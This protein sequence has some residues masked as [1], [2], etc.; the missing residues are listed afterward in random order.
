M[1]KY[2]S[3]IKA[4]LTS[5][6]SLFIINNK[7]KD[8]NKKQSKAVPI[9]I[10]C[11]IMLCF[12]AYA[13]MFIDPLKQS[14]LA[15]I[16]LSLFAFLT[17][18]LTLIEGIYKTGS[19]LFNCKDDDLLLSLPIKKSTVLFIRIF[20]FYIFELLYN[21]VFM[22]PAVVAY[23]IRVDVE[24]TFY[25]TSFFMLLLLPIIPIAISCIIGVIT[26]GLASRFKY[27]NLVQ[28]I[29][30]TI[31]FVG[32]MYVSFNLQN[33][34]DALTKNATSIN[35]LITKI[36]YPAGAFVNL[37]TDFKIVD[38]LIFIGINAGIFA[39]IVFLISKVYFKINSRTK[40]ISVVYK[41]EYK[42]KTN[43]VMSALIKKEWRRFT[44]SPVFI[45][46][47]G[48]GL[49]LYLIL[50]ILVAVNFNMFSGILS[51]QGFK[52][53]KE[54][55]VKYIPIVSV[56]LIA[57][58]S[59]LTS[60]TSSMISLEGKSFNILKSLPVSASKI[61]LAKV[62][63]AVLVML[64][65]IF[66]GDMILFIKY[67]FTILQMLLVLLVSVI[68]PLIS[69][70]I[71]IIMNLKYPKMDA[72]SDAEVVKQ[73]TSSTISVFVG[74]G[75]LGVTL[76]GLFKLLKMYG[77]DMTLLIVTGASA[78]IL[79]LLLLYMKKKSVDEFN[80]ISV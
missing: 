18:I 14:N 65:F 44:N 37:A 27:K 10:Y 43:S 12:F 79:G 49:V 46:N 13:N 72:E 17:A 36:Y 53:T 59:F 11:L 25:L 61:I 62:L 70:L 64:P 5:E 21:T 67:D 35:D 60:I 47:A 2:I 78:L 57:G 56:A 40:S 20:K 28:I 22:L 45:T 3:L 23:A 73:S 77:T 19:L 69:E 16:V 54:E 31:F 32:L 29:I 74:M 34:I 48:L 9:F 63:S 6:M 42:I 1:K 68:L 26:S 66:V 55:V 71:G 52:I 24:W 50:C 7:N 4:C 38:L 30:T 58:G 8:K 51:S 41:K 39:L 33:I 76:F 15:F 75:L 80:S